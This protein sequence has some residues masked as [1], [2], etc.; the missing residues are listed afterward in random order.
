MGSRYQYGIRNG[1]VN[2][3][4]YGNGPYTWRN[5]G[6][7]HEDRLTVAPYRYSLFEGF[8]KL[9]QLSNTIDG[10][11]STEAV[12]NCNTN[13]E[14]LGSGASDLDVTFATTVGG[15]ELQTDGGGTN[16]V[17]VLPH[18]DASQ[19]AWTGIKWG[20]ENEVIWET[21][22]RTGSA[23]TTCDIHAG[24]KLTNVPAVS[25]DDDSV[26]F[27]YAG[28]TDTNWQALNS[29]ATDD[30]AIDTGVAVAASTDYYFRIEIDA[31]RIATY[32][33]NDKQVGSSSAL[34][35]DIDFIPY[36]GILESAASA[37][38]LNIAWQ[39]ISRIMG[40]SS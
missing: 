39:A 18:L 20:T 37:R 9:P 28:G 10:A 30:T 35:N 17:I 5:D 31:A 32:Y 12:R 3:P 16:A 23:I 6:L 25:T 15:I 8:K 2:C 38:T 4:P 36:I 34:T 26:F 29:I 19:S 40:E 1:A 33:I 21:A 7:T 27:R 14:I 13:F 24:L 11:W 22:I